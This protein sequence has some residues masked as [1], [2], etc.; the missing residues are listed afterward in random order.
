MSRKIFLV[1][2]SLKGSFEALVLCET[3]CVFFHA[4]SWLKLQY[5]HYYC[6]NSP[7]L[8]NTIFSAYTLQNHLSKVW[9][10][11]IIKNL[12]CLCWI[13]VVQVLNN[14]LSYWQ[15]LIVFNNHALGFMSSSL[16]GQFW[17]REKSWKYYTS[18]IWCTCYC[19]VLCI[20]VGWWWTS[21]HCSAM[22][23][24]VS[25][26]T[27]TNHKLTPP[28]DWM[29]IK[30]TRRQKRAH[31]QRIWVDRR[32]ITEQVTR[33]KGTVNTEWS[34]LLSSRAPT[35]Y[36]PHVDTSDRSAHVNTHGHTWSTSV[37]ASASNLFMNIIFPVVL[38]DLDRHDALVLVRQV[39][40]YPHPPLPPL[41]FSS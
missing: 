16:K 36:W 41:P 33:E 22:S 30:H 1:K 40:F 35:R 13:R 26:V 18:C 21:Q 19:G 29:Q 25:A 37:G 20:S 34:I 4:H 31:T 32:Q 15:A 24:C 12:I 23:V 7:V 9:L 3:L 10:L 39:V 38:W 14:F 28:I 27:V 8:L 2:K 5:L 17:V 6:N 11:L